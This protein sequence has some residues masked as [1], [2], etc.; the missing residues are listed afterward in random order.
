MFII[1][2]IYHMSLLL[3]KQVCVQLPTYADNVALPAFARRTQ[4]CCAPCSNLSIPPAGRPHS[5]VCCC[6]PCWDRQ[7]D[8]RTDTRQMHRPCPSSTANILCSRR[9]RIITL[10]ATI[11]KSVKHRSDVS[12][13][14]SVCPSV[15]LFHD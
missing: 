9:C 7:T 3:L 15:C 14:L 10:A 12:V 13:C 4:R 8:R 1:C 11:A 5:K 2:F 6:G